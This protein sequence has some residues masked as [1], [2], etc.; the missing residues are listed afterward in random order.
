MSLSTILQK[1][2][3]W[4]GSIEKAPLYFTLHTQE[5]LIKHADEVKGIR[6]SVVHVTEKVLTYSIIQINIDK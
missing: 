4:V 1:V 3:D 6:N 2:Y 5:K